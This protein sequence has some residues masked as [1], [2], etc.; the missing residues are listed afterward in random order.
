MCI[1]CLGHLTPLHPPLTFR[2]NLFCPLLLWFCWREN[3]RDNKKDIVFL[4]LFDKDNYTVRFLVLLPFTYVL[5]PTLVY[6]YQT[7]SLLPCPL[8]MVALANLRLLYSLLY[9][10]H[11]NRFQVRGFLPFPYST[12]AHSPLSVWSM[13]NNITAFVLGL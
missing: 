3:I 11:I 6:L 5:Q 1:H 4:L 13:S 8:P 2:Q 9:N 12:R 10:E 7:S